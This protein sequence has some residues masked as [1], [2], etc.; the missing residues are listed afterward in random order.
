MYGFLDHKLVNI[1]SKDIGDDEKFNTKIPTSITYHSPLIIIYPTKPGSS[2]FPDVMRVIKKLAYSI[3][4]REEFKKARG[5]S[6]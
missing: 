5:I 3:Y 4:H 2:E 6:L 1:A